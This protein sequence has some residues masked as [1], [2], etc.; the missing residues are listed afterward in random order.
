MEELWDIYDINRKKTNKVAGRETHEFT[1]G[2][3]HLITVAVIINSKDEILTAK[4]AKTKKRDPL[5][6]ELSGGGVRAGESSLEAI[7][8]EAKEE[9]GLSFKQEDAIL[10]KEVRRDN[11][12]GGGSFKDFWLFKSNIDAE[13]IK[14]PDKEATEAKWVTIDE[15]MKMQEGGKVITG[16]DFEKEDYELAIKILTNS[17]RNNKL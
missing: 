5:K 10:L 8:R 3:Y 1:N 14:F 17:E 9:I 15:F 13:Q 12:K 16:L 7:I 11:E 4:R 6:W 2:E